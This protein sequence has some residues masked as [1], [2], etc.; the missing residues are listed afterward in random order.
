VAEP[1][2]L[3][4]DVL[5]KLVLDRRRHVIGRADGIVLSMRAD[6]P[7]RVAAI[8]MG[9]TTLARRLSTRL[10][11][12]ISG[13]ER[14]LGVHDGKPLR[15]PFETVTIQ[16]NQLAADIDGDEAGAYV[17]ERWWRHHLVE[18]LPWSGSK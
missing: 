8:E 16:R 6:R 18:R 14:W 15:I 3:A 2:L 1:T 12:W 13:V 5:D 10:E 17:W 11:R 9:M 7:P 4:R